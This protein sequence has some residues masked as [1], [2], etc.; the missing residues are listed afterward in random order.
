MPMFV[1]IFIG[2]G[3]SFL[4]EPLS[5]AS[6]TTRTKINQV[7]R[8]SFNKGFLENDKYDNNRNNEIIDQVEADYQDDKK[9]QGD[10]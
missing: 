1:L 4:P 7:L 5:T 6:L 8:G 10:N 2:Y 9:N 3:D